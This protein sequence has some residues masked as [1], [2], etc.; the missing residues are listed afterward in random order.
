MSYLAI[1]SIF[2]LFLYSMFKLSKSKNLNLAKIFNQSSDLISQVPFIKKR[3]KKKSII[4]FIKY[5]DQNIG[6]QWTLKVSVDLIA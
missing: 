2:G 3:R 6:I 4:R 1:L 5:Y